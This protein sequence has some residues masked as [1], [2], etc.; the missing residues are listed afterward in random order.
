MTAAG[1]TAVVALATAALPG[2]PR[3][4]ASV[5]RTYPDAPPPAHTGG[6]G[7]PTCHACHSEHEPQPPDRALTIEGLPQRYTAG[8]TYTITVRLARSGVRNAGFQLAV[9]FAEGPAQSAQAGRFEA[10]GPD[11]EIMTTGSPPVS[12]AHQTRA[13]ARL[14]VPDTARWVLRWTAPVRPHPVLLN[15][16]ANAGNDDASPLG[17]VTYARAYRLVATAI[18]PQGRFDHAASARAPAP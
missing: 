6:F 13:G 2:L 14:T 4:A 5:S 17:D 8:K 7:E 16:A 11:V 12:Y 15:L 1:R 9:R 10:I 3:L 18:P